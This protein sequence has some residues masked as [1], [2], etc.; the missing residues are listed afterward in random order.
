MIELTL[1]N[2]DVIELDNLDETDAVESVAS[3]DTGI[4]DGLIFRYIETGN[5]KAIQEYVY[6]V[7]DNFTSAQI[8]AL[9]DAGFSLDTIAEHVSS[10]T[11]SQD[12]DE[13]LDGNEDEI[14]GEFVNHD[15][16]DYVRGTIDPNDFI[17]TLS[18]EGVEVL[19]DGTVIDYSDL[20]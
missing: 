17:R 14:F 11:V 9:S 6:T 1:M 15:M 12:A 16:Y 3:N 13:W 4:P 20:I 18:P 8:T 5:V 19:S 2:G 7:T 10:I